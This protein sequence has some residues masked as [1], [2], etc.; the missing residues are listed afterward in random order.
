[1]SSPSDLP[2]DI[3]AAF[4]EPSPAVQIT[5]LLGAAPSEHLRTLY[6]LYVAQI[7]TIV[8]AGAAEWE[9]R[10]SIVVGLALARQKGESDEEEIAVERE[11]FRGIMEGLQNL[12]KGENV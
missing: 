4:P 3:K 12:M 9:L 5:P 6:S 2:N 7:A 11:I 1:L 8:W 10:K